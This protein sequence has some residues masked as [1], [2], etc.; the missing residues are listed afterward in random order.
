MRRNEMK[1]KYAYSARV[2]YL[3]PGRMD[4]HSFKESQMFYGDSAEACRKL[5]MRKRNIGT[6]I[7][8]KVRKIKRTQ[9]VQEEIDAMLWDL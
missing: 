1:A 7:S 2:T 6:L 3:C 8:Y 5:V 4:G 9:R